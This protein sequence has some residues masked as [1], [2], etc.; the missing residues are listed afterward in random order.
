MESSRAYGRVAR[1]KAAAPAISGRA[2]G[3]VIGVALAVASVSWLMAFVLGAGFVV[4]AAVVLAV[5]AILCLA[6]ANRNS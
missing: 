2:A 3:S 1:R 5:F 6:G 4:S